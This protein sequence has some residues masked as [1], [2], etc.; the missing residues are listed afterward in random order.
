[1]TRAYCEDDLLCIVRNA[2]K[3]IS[4]WNMLLTLMTIDVLKKSSGLEESINIERKK[5]TAKQVIA[6]K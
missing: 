3:R 1:M 4:M 2:N 6:K 5:F